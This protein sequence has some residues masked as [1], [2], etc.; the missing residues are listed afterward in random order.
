MQLGRALSG[1]VC[2]DTANDADFDRADGELIDQ[3]TQSA[4][5]AGG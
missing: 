1:A 3:K 4:G 5:G 2:F